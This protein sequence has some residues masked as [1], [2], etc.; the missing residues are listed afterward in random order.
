[1]QGESNAPRNAPFRY[2]VAVCLITFKRPNLLRKTLSSLEQ[3]VFDDNEP[4]IQVVVVDND[5]DRSALSIVNEIKPDFRWPLEYEVEE[6]PG[7][8][9]A[10]NTAVSFAD[11]PYVAFIDDDEIAHPSW[12][13]ELISTQVT[14]QA[15]LV[16]GPVVSSIEEGPDWIRDDAF[17]RPRFTT[18]FSPEIAATGNLLV[19]KTVFDA[20][21]KPFDEE[22]QSGSDTLFS[23]RARQ[24]GFKIVWADEAL[25][26]ENVPSER[27]SV[28]WLLRRAYRGGNGYAL[29]ETS[30]DQSV[31]IRMLRP[32]KAVIRILQGILICL[33]GLVTLRRIV[34]IRGLQRLS[35]GCG[36]LT[37]L[38]G[39]RFNEYERA[40]A[41]SRKE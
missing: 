40:N 36:M 22:F 21:E 5:R 12:L 32:M 1:M 23:L 10:R 6:K 9:A 8:P 2:D 41:Y 34:Q 19:K 3:L 33:W 24:E 13:K 30:I 20:L 14:F 26:T 27:S 17:Q 11:A 31:R 25:V 15:D 16:T 29:A 18:G 37:A 35:M 7:I 4:K 28:R 38:L 39:K